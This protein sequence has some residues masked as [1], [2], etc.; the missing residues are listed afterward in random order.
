MCVY[1]VPRTKPGTKRKIRRRLRDARQAPCATAKAAGLPP[2][3]EWSKDP[4][5]STILRSAFGS[6]MTTVGNNLEENHSVMLATAVPNDDYL[7]NRTMMPLGNTHSPRGDTPRGDELPAEGAEVRKPGKHDVLLGRGGGTNNHEGNVLFRQLVNEH[8]M[9]YL[10]CNKVDKPKVAREVVALWRKLDPPGRF[11]ARKDESKRGPGSVKDDNNIWIEVGDKKAREKAS[12]CL[13]ERTADVLP[14]LSRLRQHQD[15]MTEQGV[16]LVEQQLSMNR[17]ANGSSSMNGSP[18]NGGLGN[19]P[20]RP[21]SATL[22]ARR[23]SLPATAHSSSFGMSGM[24]MQDRRTSTPTMN[25]LQ[26]QQPHSIDMGNVFAQ[27]QQALRQQYTAIE[28]SNE[29]NE[30]QMMQNRMNGYGNSSMEPQQLQMMRSQMLAQQEQQRRMMAQSPMSMQNMSP[31]ASP[32][33]VYSEPRMSPTNSDRTHHLARQQ[34][35]LTQEH[36]LLV[37]ERDR[38]LRQ[39]Q[40]IARRNAEL[41]RQQMLVHQQHLAAQMQ[42]QAQIS[43]IPLEGQSS[44]APVPVNVQVPFEGSE[45]SG[46]DPLPYSMEDLT[47]HA[48]LPPD[49]TTSQ[50]PRMVTPQNQTNGQRSP[51]SRK[52]KKVP[53]TS[54]KKQVAK[55]SNDVLEEKKSDGDKKPY[56]SNKTPDVVYEKTNKSKPNSPSGKKVGGAAPSPARSRMSMGDATFASQETP[57]SMDNVLAGLEN[58]ASS[59]AGKQSYEKNVARFISNHKV[60]TP[61]L[62]FDDEASENEAGL[63]VDGIDTTQWI[64]EALNDSGDNSF[65]NKRRVRRNSKFS[66]MSMTSSIEDMSV[67]LSDMDQSNEMSSL[68]ERRMSGNQSVMS[69]LTDFDELDCL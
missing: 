37:A 68:R 52:S 55:L 6:F 51:A 26:G 24:R 63:S 12:Q 56:A 60:T 4:N 35:M 2:R 25:H 61:N 21:T 40:L 16:A 38:L 1:L 41:E 14:Y 67:A 50:D 10:A 59:K 47:P 66:D 48:V 5:S 27:Q 13:R 8:K 15:Q 58:E 9:R 42:Q 3:K 36:Q 39:E 62:N 34:Q 31:A 23:G 44:S 49:T 29:I 69:E 57:L 33:Q 45:R 17:A 22:N 19:M 18:M 46:V 11:L 64:E 32:Q 53:S 43:P 7:A 30:M 28:R 65:T 20:D 54:P